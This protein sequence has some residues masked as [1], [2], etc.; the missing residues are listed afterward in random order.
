MLISSVNIE[1]LCAALTDYE[2]RVPEELIALCNRLLFKGIEDR[3]ENGTVIMV[4]GSPDCTRNRSPKAAEAFFENRA[5]FILLSGGKPM[6]DDSGLTECE[7]MRAQLRALGVPNER[8]ILENKSMYT[9][10]NVMFS[11][12]IIK[13]LFDDKAMKILAVSG[14]SHMRRVMLNFAHYRS[15]FARETQVLPVP[16]RSSSTDEGVLQMVN[17][18]RYAAARECLALVSYVRAGYLPDVEI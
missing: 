15:I 16:A 14:A 4:F 8:I 13:A 1:R 5:P 18:G 9:H 7:A 17:R 10:E 2:E 3:G 6:P 12:D 11:A